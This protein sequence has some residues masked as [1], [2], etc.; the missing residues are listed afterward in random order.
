MRKNKQPIWLENRPNRNVKSLDQSAN[1][2]FEVG[3]GGSFAD[4]LDKE[5]EVDLFIQR[6]TPK[7]QKVVR[8]LYE[9]YKQA[10]IATKLGVSHQAI[11]DI[12]K[13]IK[14]KLPF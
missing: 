12:I 1:D 5:I 4:Q 13:T 14:N 6:L 9:G 10:E 11:T 2:G 3:D 7:Q 8:M